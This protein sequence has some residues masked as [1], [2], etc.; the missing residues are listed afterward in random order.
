M[1]ASNVCTPTVGHIG[2][3]FVAIELSQRTWLVTIH[4]PDRDR[5]SRHKLDGGDHAG[6]WH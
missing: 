2:I 1:Q 6:C 3:I 4:S 5:L